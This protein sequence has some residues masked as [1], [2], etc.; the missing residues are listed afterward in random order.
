[1]SFRSFSR[2]RFL[3]SR[4]PCFACSIARL[5]EGFHASSVPRE[6]GAK[7]RKGKDSWAF[8]GERIRR[9]DPGKPPEGKPACTSDER[10]ARRG[11]SARHGGPC[12]P[13]GDGKEDEDLS[14]DRGGS[15]RRTERERS[16]CSILRSGSSVGGGSGP[17]GPCRAGGAGCFRPTI[18]LR[19]W[20]RQGDRAR[21]R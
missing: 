10:S 6:P 1:M 2:S 12:A 18:G 13:Q 15:S 14:G 9:F 5:R 17:S 11:G 4:P 20:P 8:C 19:S 7:Y 16:P 21:E 3:S